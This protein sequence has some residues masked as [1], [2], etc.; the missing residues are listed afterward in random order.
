MQPPPDPV[1]NQQVQSKA[2]PSGNVFALGDC[3]DSPGWRTLVVAEADTATV[4][5]NITLL[6]SRASASAVPS[7]KK[8]K[9]GMKVLVVP[10]GPGGGSGFMNVPLLGDVTM[11]SFMVTAIKAKSLFV[12]K[13]EQRFAV[14]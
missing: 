3:A 9:P 11:P 8:H 1:S 2:F 5:S 6:V 14:A 13:F 4:A 7:L 12:D 10:L